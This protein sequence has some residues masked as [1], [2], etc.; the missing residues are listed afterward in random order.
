MA[1]ATLGD[2]GVSLFVA[3]AIFGEVAVML[4]C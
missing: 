4:E 2:V 3:P 1:G